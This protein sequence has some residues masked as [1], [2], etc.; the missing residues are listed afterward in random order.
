MILD[1]VILYDVEFFGFLSGKWNCGKCVVYFWKIFILF[2]IKCLFFIGYF[3]FLLFF[4]L[5]E[6]GGDLDFGFWKDCFWGFCGDCNNWFGELVGGVGGEMGLEVLFI[7]FVELG[8]DNCFGDR[9]WFWINLFK[10]FLRIC[11]VLGIDSYFRNSL[12]IFIFRIG[13]RCVMYW[14]LKLFW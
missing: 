5:G 11:C 10:L 7:V 4:N 2:K 9:G 3:V 14:W 12:L 6:C 8:F 13:E 1:N